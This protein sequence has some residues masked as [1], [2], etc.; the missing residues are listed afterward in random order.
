[1]SAAAVKKM[2]LD[3]TI[4]SARQVY[5]SLLRGVNVGG[6]N[7]IIKGDLIKCY[8]S[9]GCGNVTTYIQSGNIVFDACKHLPRSAVISKIKKYLSSYLSDDVEVM[10]LT[11]QEFDE[12]V[13]LAETFFNKHSGNAD[14]S[15]SSGSAAAKSKGSP[16]APVKEYITLLCTGV[17]NAKEAEGDAACAAM[18]SYVDSCLGTSGS[19]EGGSSSSTSASS[20]SGSG[21]C[22]RRHADALGSAADTPLTGTTEAAE[23][24]PDTAYVPVLLFY[25]P[26]GVLES[27]FGSKLLD[28]IVKVPTT[29]RNL[30]T[31]RQLRDMAQRVQSQS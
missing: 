16:K 6:G 2:R 1:M 3:S 13:A 14:S 23:V 15:S 19:G 21:S 20:S 28:K 22:K 29:T 24:L 9:A 5:V 8:D 4:A 12:I 11:K 31:M 25:S 17:G 26:L 27:K 10:V 18:Q 7:R 30:N